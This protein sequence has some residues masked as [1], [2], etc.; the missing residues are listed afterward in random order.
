MRMAFTVLGVAGLGLA[1]AVPLAGQ[2]A[3]PRA[4][5]L[6]RDARAVVAIDV[7]SGRVVGT[8]SLRQ[9]DAAV[10]DARWPAAAGAGARPGP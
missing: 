6:D 1:A 5:A 8:A 3:G 9:P 2:A 7:A 4:F 10:A